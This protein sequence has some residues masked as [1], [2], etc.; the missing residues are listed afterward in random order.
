MIRVTAPPLV[1]LTV[2][3]FSLVSYNLLFAQE[4]EK[5]QGTKKPP[6]K[7]NKWKLPGYWSKLNLTEDQENRLKS[8]QE[9]FQ[10][11]LTLAA[12]DLRNLT[13]QMVQLRFAGAAKKKQ[14]V[15]SAKLT[16]KRKE[17]WQLAERM[18]TKMKGVLTS[19]Q[20]ARL[21]KMEVPRRFNFQPA[22]L[23]LTDGQLQTL[24]LI[25]DKYTPKMLCAR[26]EF[27]ELQSIYDG[28]DLFFF[29]TSDVTQL[30]IYQ[31]Q[32]TIVRRHME[33]AQGHWREL[34]EEMFLEADKV[35]TAKQ[36]NLLEKP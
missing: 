15:I 32:M 12:T 24:S 27:V 30:R 16:C 31:R 29:R 17:N 14:R 34:V 11:K 35:L 5:T 18:A 2:S 20:K 25:L 4:E 19:E 36:R 28:I 8:I 26:V 1:Y 13:R 6:V 3:A 23:G 7:S 10:R 9:K 33:D 21:L 22:I